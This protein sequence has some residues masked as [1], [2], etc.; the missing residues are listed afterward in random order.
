MDT[1]SR[2]CEWDFLS[3][4]SRVGQVEKEEGNRKVQRDEAVNA[5]VDL[6]AQARER[7]DTETDV[8]M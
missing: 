4:A 5:I 7:G 3:P 2:C 8:C 6:I 1:L